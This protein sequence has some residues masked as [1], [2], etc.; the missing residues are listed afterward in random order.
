MQS[1]TAPI[2]EG[3]SVRLWLYRWGYWRAT[4]YDALFQFPIFLRH[5]LIG[6]HGIHLKNVI[7][8]QVN[9]ALEQIV[10]DAHGFRSVSPRR[11]CPR[12]IAAVL[13]TS[14]INCLTNW[15]LSSVL[16][17]RIDFLWVRL[18]TSGFR[19][20]QELLCRLTFALPIEAKSVTVFAEKLR[21]YPH[22]P[23]AVCRLHLEKRR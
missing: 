23:Q 1:K 6:Q 10:I 11:P 13:D 2:A 21:S 22:F 16:S 9:R 3:G 5:Q 8:S 7:K 15:I 12:Q 4:R 14:R 17:I 20:P 18:E 19:F